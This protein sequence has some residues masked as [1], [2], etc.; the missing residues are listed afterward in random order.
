MNVRNFEKPRPGIRSHFPLVP[1]GATLFPLFLLLLPSFLR[2]GTVQYNSFCDGAKN[3]IK[4]LS[5]TSS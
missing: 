3:T 4:L 2:T 1:A 5:Y